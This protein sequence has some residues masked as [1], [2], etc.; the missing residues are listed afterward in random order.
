MKKL[1]VGN[2]PY[3]ATEDQ[4]KEL[5]TVCGTVSN[6]NIINKDKDGRKQCFAFVEMTEGAKDAITMINE[7]EFGG[8]K[9][10]V[11]EARERQSKPQR[12][13]GRR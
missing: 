7:R 3:S 12:E 11:S 13:Y 2:V 4:L 5:F 8:R 6:V 1:F 10:F 9:L